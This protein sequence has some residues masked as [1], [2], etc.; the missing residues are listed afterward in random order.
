MSTLVPFAIYMLGGMLLMIVLFYA[1]RGRIPIAAGRSQLRILRFSTLQRATHWSVATTFILLGLTGVLLLLGRTL[2]I[3]LMGAEAFSYVAVTAKR[4]HDFVGPVFGV[5][6]IVQFFLFLRGNFFSPKEDTMWLLKGGGLL[7]SHA[8]SHRYNF[9]EK[10]WFWLAML[11]GF[12][13]IA[14]GLILDFPIFGQDRTIM[15][16]SHII[17]SLAALVIFTAS[18]G[19]IYVG[20]IGMEGALEGMTTGY[21]DANWAREHHDLWYADHV[22][23]AEPYPA[24]NGGDT[25]AEANKAVPDA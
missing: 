2:F 9:G 10:T 7:G 1:I 14:T 25:P 12:V 11:G 5:A 22:E 16:L 13:A 21:S 4:I 18:L 15:S 24:G 17:H 23:S 6:L 19:H 3:P 8:S 20:T